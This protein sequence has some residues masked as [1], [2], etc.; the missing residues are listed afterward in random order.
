[1]TNE[2]LNYG[3][4]NRRRKRILFYICLAAIPTIQFLL[5]YVYVNFNSILLVFQKYT[6]R[7]DGL[8]Y[9]ISFG[10]AENISEA[11]KVFS[12]SGELVLNSLYLYLCN[13]VIVS[14]L[15][16]FFSYYIAKKYVLSGFFRVILFLPT[17][18]SQVAMVTMYRYIVNEAFVQIVEALGGGGWLERKGLELGLLSGTETS[19]YLTI[20]F[21][22]IWVSFGS[23]VLIYTGSMSSIDPSI[24][25]SAQLDGVNF[26]KE[27]IHIYI[28][29]IWPTFTTFV[30]TGMTTIFT[31]TMH[32]T[33]FYGTLEQ[34]PF[35]V[36]GYFLYKN[37]VHSDVYT[38]GRAYNYSVLS[39]IGVIITLIIVPITLTTRWAMEKFG[40]RTDK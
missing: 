36:F 9:D 5:F 40:P 28:P 23:N 30:V 21:Y 14:T 34:T 31:S 7:T 39:G 12:S 26:I 37:T 27:F 24:I 11:W 13:L 16:L 20:L 8:G 4:M 3:H 35:S 1:M 6:E 29:L 2:K 32:L 25:E 10:F 17:I 19:K 33:A 22:N 38:T 18:L 15:A